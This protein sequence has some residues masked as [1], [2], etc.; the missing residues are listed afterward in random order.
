MPESPE[1][2]ELV[3]ELLFESVELFEL[4]D[5]ELVVFEA[6]A[7]LL[8]L[9]EFLE[10]FEEIL[11]LEEVFAFADL[12]VLL[13]D[14]EAVVFEDA[15]LLFPEDVDEVALETFEFFEV[16]REEVLLSA[17]PSELSALETTEY[18][19]V[20]AS[21]FPSVFELSEPQDAINDAAKIPITVTVISFLNFI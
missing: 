7:E 15:V 19:P 16:F 14:F 9:F 13:S 3:F 8:E 11:E 2:F 18:V 6:D 20:L 4:F 21:D 12:L 10:F 17:L 1:F 5:L